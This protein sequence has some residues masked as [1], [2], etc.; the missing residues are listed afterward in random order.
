MSE[1]PKNDDRAALGLR[2]MRLTGEGNSEGE[3]GRFRVDSTIMADILQP[4]RMEGS[5]TFHN[6]IKPIAP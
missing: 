6:C 1:L 4:N 2:E 3:E 5:V